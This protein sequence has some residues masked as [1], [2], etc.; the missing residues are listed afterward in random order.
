MKNDFP[1]NYTSES[2]KF[3]NSKVEKKIKI[4]DNKIRKIKNI[5]NGNI[6]LFQLNTAI[7][8]FL[9]IANLFINILSNNNKDLFSSNISK[10]TLKIKKIGYSKIFCSTGYF[11]ESKKYPNKVCINGNFQEDIKSQ[12]KLNKT[13]NLIELI[14]NES[15]DNISYMF[16]GC[17]NIT[18]IDLSN[19]SSSTVKSMEFMFDGCKSLTSINF[20]N[21]DTSKVMNMQ[22]MFNECSSLT[23]L[24]LSDFNTAHVTNMH[25]MFYGCK[26]LTSLNLSN[27]ETTQVTN[28]DFMFF[29]CIY[30]EYINLKNFNENRLE[31]NKYNSMFEKLPDN[32]VVCINSNKTIS[33]ILPQITSKKC[34]TLYCS[35]DW[36]SKQK[37]II[38][39]TL[40]TDN[41]YNSPRNIYEDNGKCYEQ[42]NKGY[43]K[44]EINTNITKCKC[45]L[46]KCLFCPP[47]PFS[48]N[49]CTK[50]NQDYYPME[51]DPSNIGVYINCY[52]E[53]QGYYLDRN[54]SIYKKCYYTCET[55]EIGG[56]NL[57]HNCLFCKSNF[58]K[59]IIINNIKHCYEN[60][61]YYFYIDNEHNYHCTKE[62]SCP[63]DYPDLNITEKRCFNS[64]DKYKSS[65]IYDTK[66]EEYL[67]T[68]EST[69][70]SNNNNKDNISYNYSNYT[71]TEEEQFNKSSELIKTYKNEFYTDYII[72]NIPIIIESTQLELKITNIDIEQMIQKILNIS[73]KEMKNNDKIEYYDSILKI[74][75]SIITSGNYDTSLI[76]IG[77]DKIIEIGKMTI[78]LTTTLNQKN[79]TNNN[80][81]S[82]YLEQCETLLREYYNISDD[83]LIY[84]KKIDVIQEGM[85]IAKVEYDVYTKLFGENLTKLNLSICENAK[86][87][88]T[89][90]V[91]INEN[92]D[93]L[94]SSSEYYKDICYKSKSDSGTDIIINDRKK[95]L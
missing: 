48:L 53:K 15:I 83:Q 29:G 69:K 36:K 65:F 1:K 80:M 94:N 75:D 40:C 6:I 92:I 93:I 23:S 25:Y 63:E 24:N 62:N 7:I 28:M 18:E 72:N 77:E 91:K 39:E 11:F 8:K 14:W 21:F 16:E 55:C 30:L 84:I 67:L 31:S 22:N 78:T 76:D 10:I 90:P 57:F 64:N 34:Y 43:E 85:K 59:E 70:I 88:I 42:C 41:C 52:K 9:F 79:N 35:K 26:S 73:N 17:S 89:V 2:D 47:V 37:K 3:L 45:Q 27:F 87:S 32:I 82:I 12:Y 81:T 20:K 60:C 4:K 74:I 61:D 54:N 68:S 33:K 50:C 38:N 19:F 66:G 49:L 46:D 56:S 5:K 95:N 86:I 58:S 13:D 71:D 51:N 44:D